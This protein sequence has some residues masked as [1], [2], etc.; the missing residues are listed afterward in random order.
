MR[1]LCCGDRNWTDREVIRQELLKLPPDTVIIEGE[2]RGADRISREVAVE[3]G[4]QIMPF[5]ADWTR[6]GRAAGPIRNHQMLV[7]AQPQLVLAFHNNIEN[8]KGTKNMVS[9][10]RAAH[11]IV[12]IITELG[13]DYGQT[14]K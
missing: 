12:K 11:V 13:E 7:E 10:A 5:P 3:M 2:A 4:L 1:V 14:V 6:Y 9:I 8:S